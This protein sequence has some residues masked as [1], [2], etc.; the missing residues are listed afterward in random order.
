MKVTVSI[1]QNTI[2]ALQKGSNASWCTEVRKSGAPRTLPPECID[3]DL[4]IPDPP[5]RTILYRCG[6]QKK[7]N[8]HCTNQH[9]CTGDFREEQDYRVYHMVQEEKAE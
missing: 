3:F 1:H 4:E 7:A 6:L 8:G 9:N 5:Y 2:A